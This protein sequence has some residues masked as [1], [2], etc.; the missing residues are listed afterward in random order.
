[1]TVIQVVRRCVDDAGKVEV[2]GD[3]GGAGTCAAVCDDAQFRH[4]DGAAALGQVS[5][6]NR[7]ALPGRAGSWRL[8]QRPGRLAPPPE[9]RQTAA[10]V[11]LS[12][13][14]RRKVL[15]AAQIPP[16][17]PVRN[18]GTTSARGGLGSLDSSRAEI[19]CIPVE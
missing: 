2:A 7:S 6:R 1:M 11:A 9:P 4:D 16:Y 13:R 10:R 5:D 15:S 12:F 17:N 8:F 14:H 19:R 18:L 3:G